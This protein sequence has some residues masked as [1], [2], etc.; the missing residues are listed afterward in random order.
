[1]NLQSIDYY[2]MGMYLLLVLALGVYFRKHDKTKLDFFLAG[3]SMGWVTIGLSV[4]V[5]VFSVVNYMALP[6]EVFAN[7]LYVIIS[8]PVFF[9][10]AFIVS[11][12]WMPFFYKLRLS[13]VY[14]YFELRFSVK[15]R[16]LA[17]VVFIVW[18]VFWMATALYAAGML[19]SKMSGINIYYVIL[20]AGVVATVYTSLGGIRAVMWT[21]C[22]QF[23]V[24][25]GGIVVGLYVA[26]QS[27][28]A[29]NFLDVAYS[30]GRLKPLYPFDPAYFSFDPHIRISFWSG[31][32]GVTVA[33][34]TRYGADQ[35]VVQRYFTAKS[36]QAAQKG[37][38]LNATAAFVA[39]SLLVLFGIAVYVHAVGSGTLDSID[40]N[41]LPVSKRKAIAMKEFIVTIKSLPAGVFGLV[42][43]GLLAATMSSID[44]GINA[45]TN[46]FVTDVLPIFMG[47]QEKKEFSGIFVVSIFGIIC[48]SSGL[49]LVTL[50]GQTKSLFVIVNQIVNALGSPLLA[51]FILAMF[52]KRANSVG[53]LWGGLVGFA[54]SIYFSV[55]V[56]GIALHYYAAINLLV[57]MGAIYLISV[58]AGA[59]GKGDYQD[60]LDYCCR[61]PLK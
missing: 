35:V 10:A 54:F 38:W 61:R 57:T 8:L 26:Q 48:I 55:W 56:G 51:L 21:D 36:L 24:L 6:T 3:R 59:L 1:M 2:I 49:I 34:L 58:I 28:G 29:E 11:K 12:I 37:I 7:G 18:R 17:S 43:S 41:A 22:L 42:V 23:V 50:V 25:F 9:L 32:V 19:L 60:K 16:I 20:I 33:F 31:L 15:V 14:E 52:S 44:S 27:I 46:S 4:M 45:C 53:A 40:L 47:K 30:G 39:L 13:S 5:T